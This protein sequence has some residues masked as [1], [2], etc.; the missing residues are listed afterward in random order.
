MSIVST[1]SLKLTE[2]I[3]LQATNAA[4]ELGM[5]PHA[6]MV[7]AIKQAS[8]NAEIRRNFIQQANIAREGVI[9]NGKV[10]E[11]DKVFEAMKSRIAGKKST[12]KVSNW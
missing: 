8:I 7:E 6:F 9:K 5:T 10:F 4:K 11:S 12:L 3:K 2:E 1:T